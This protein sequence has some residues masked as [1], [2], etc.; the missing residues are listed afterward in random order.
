MKA[1]GSAKRVRVPRRALAE[2]AKPP[3]ESRSVASRLG[4]RPSTE[5]AVHC[6][7]QGLVRGD[8][9]HEHDDDDFLGGGSLVL[10]L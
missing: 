4:A 9:E 2:T 7:M 8:E 10:F 5:T 3:R 1:C 6:A